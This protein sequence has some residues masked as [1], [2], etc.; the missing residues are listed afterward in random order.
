LFEFRKQEEKSPSNNCMEWK[1][2]ILYK[3]SEKI[4]SELH[5]HY[6][7]ASGDPQK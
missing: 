3:F 1:V 6:F 5:V 4:S 2:Y 7:V